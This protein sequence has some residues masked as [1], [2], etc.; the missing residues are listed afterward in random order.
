MEYVA[1]GRGLLVPDTKIKV[2]GRFDC[3]LVRK[4]LIID[5]W[6]EDN[7]VVNQG[8]NSL[9][10]VYFNSGAQIT[11][12]YLGIFQG[13]YVPVATD[14][15]ANVA[16]NATECSSYTSATRPVWTPAAPSS[17]S[18]TNSASPATFTFNASQT[19]YGAF[20]DSSNVI[21]GTAGTLFSEAQFATPKTVVNLD[22]LLL[23]YTFNASSN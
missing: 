22:Q 12:W 4:G 7:L 16:V 1:N 14:T 11:A 3:K 23:T 21:A 13:N 9:L 17:Q 19:I 18:I 5:E 15:A 2:W 20:L 10:S 8:L 6:S